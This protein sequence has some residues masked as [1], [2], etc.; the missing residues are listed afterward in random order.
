MAKT[1]IEFEA[2]FQ[3]LVPSIQYGNFTLKDKVKLKRVVEDDDI[4]PATEELAEQANTQVIQAV[5]S[6][7]K[8]VDKLT[9]E[10][11]AL[12]VDTINKFKKMGFLT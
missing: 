10:H 2:E 3:I 7:K 8:Q 12:P 9:L 4:E 11:A 1:E 5:L 6:Q